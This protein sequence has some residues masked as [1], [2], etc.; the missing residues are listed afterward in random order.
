MSSSVNGIVRLLTRRTFVP[1]APRIGGAPRG[2]VRANLV[3][4]RTATP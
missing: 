3:F 1:G 2:G 4:A